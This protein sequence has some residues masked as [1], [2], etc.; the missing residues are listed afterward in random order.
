MNRADV[1]K[2]LDRERDFQEMIA[3]DWE[4]KGTP[5]VSEELLIMEHY[6]QLVRK[7]WVT[8]RGSDP[9]LNQMRKICAVAIR[10]FEHH[11][12]PE[13]EGTVDKKGKLVDIEYPRHG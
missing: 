4:N 3:S 2:V 9:C 1:Y 5:T 6:I 12:V 10:C 8:K 11:G 7:A 13:R